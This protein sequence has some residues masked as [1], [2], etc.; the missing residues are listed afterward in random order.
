MKTLFFRGGGLNTLCHARRPD[1]TIGPMEAKHL[2]TRLARR[3]LLLTWLTAWAAFSLPWTSATTTAHWERV[4][5]PRVRAQSRVRLHHVLN[6]LFYVP[7]SPLASTLGWPISIGV[8][9][10]AALSLTAESVQL[11]SEN[12]A[13]DGNDIIANVGG[14]TVGAV[15]LALCKRRIRNPRRG[16]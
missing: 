15:A 5:A 2:G 16:P 9:G 1:A 7:S 13:P 12:R 4:R 11:F 10:G 3:W 8:M 6:V 14:A